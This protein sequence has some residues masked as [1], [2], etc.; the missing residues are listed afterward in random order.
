MIPKG[1]KTAL[2]ISQVLDEIGIDMNA[3]ARY[4]YF[5]LL[6]SSLLGVLNFNFI[7]VVILSDKK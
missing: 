5:V 4:C 7:S 6:P 2:S 1:K 3:K